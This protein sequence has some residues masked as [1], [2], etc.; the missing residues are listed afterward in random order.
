MQSKHV[1]YLVSADDSRNASCNKI[2]NMIS[3]DHHFYFPVMSIIKT[4]L[5]L[6]IV[7]IS[8]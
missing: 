3:F 8:I 7:P 4:P 5:K 2:Q 6:Q 1:A